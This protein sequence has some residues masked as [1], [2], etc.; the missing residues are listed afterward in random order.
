MV[1]TI[2]GVDCSTDDR[3]VGLARGHFDERCAHIEDLPERSE[4]KP[5]D[6][7][8][9]WIIQ[10]KNTPILLALDA[11]LGWPSS[12]AE[13][14]RCHRAGEPLSAVEADQM[15]RRRTD[16]VVAEKVKKRS[17]DVGADRIART[18]YAA[19][20]LLDRL[21][22]ETKQD[23]PLA[24][25]L[26]LDSRTYAIEVYPAATLRMHGLPDKGYKGKGDEHLA[27]RD[28][29][30]RGMGKESIELPQSRRQRQL[31]KGYDHALD[32]VVCV[33]AGV[34]FLQRKAIRPEDVGVPLS[35]A[36]KESWIWVKKPN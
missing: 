11:P 30:L 9:D 28:S 27:E 31:L 19:L 13:V 7:I 17:L 22:L 36:Q 14:L 3:K 32:A 18:A 4:G 8:A 15:F 35:L 12:L 5:V 29:I 24:W 34:D 10:Y 23:I 21:R 16:K 20:D 2:I 33:L 1:T 6:I 25:K 26:P